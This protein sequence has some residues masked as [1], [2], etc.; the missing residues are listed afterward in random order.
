MAVGEDGT[1]QRVCSQEMCQRL[2]ATLSP[3]EKMVVEMHF[4]GGFSWQEVAE[5][6]KIDIVTV[7]RTAISAFIKMRTG[8][9]NFAGLKPSRPYVYGS[10]F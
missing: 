10:A 9:N 1:E 7:R 8:E 2:L 6:K 3:E 4:F 5:E